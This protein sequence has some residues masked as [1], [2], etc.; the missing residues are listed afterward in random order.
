MSQS[1]GGTFDVS[2][3]K[4][5]KQ[6][7]EVL[8]TGGNTHL[9]GADFDRKMMQHCINDILQKHKVDI[10]SNKKALGKLRRACEMAKKTLSAQT[11]AK[12]VVELLF[13][14]TDYKY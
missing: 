11:T 9:G 13:K 10:T 4:V 2:V 7:F 8:G 5:K 3:A 1:G 6:N 12:I 14:Q